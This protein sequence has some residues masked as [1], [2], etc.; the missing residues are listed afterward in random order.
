MIVVDAS[1]LIG[2]IEAEDAHHRN[3]V[4][5]LAGA[6]EPFFVHAVTLAEVLVGPA[7]VGTEE[8]VAADLRGIGVR[9]ANLGAGEAIA[10]ARLRAR[11][12]LKMPDICALATAIHVGAPLATFDAKLAAAARGLGLLYEADP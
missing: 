4:A 7:R 2:L 10:L 12:G 1:P 3:A 6:A 11:L 5:L 8:A 9:V